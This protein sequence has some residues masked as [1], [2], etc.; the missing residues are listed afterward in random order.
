[1]KQLS[2]DTEQGLLPIT[3]LVNGLRVDFV[4]TKQLEVL[5]SI[6]STDYLEPVRHPLQLL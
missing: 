3:A 6:V 5:G 4:A 2:T 1:M